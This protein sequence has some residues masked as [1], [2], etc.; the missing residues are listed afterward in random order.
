VQ[1]SISH[2]LVYIVF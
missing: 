1:H 2:W